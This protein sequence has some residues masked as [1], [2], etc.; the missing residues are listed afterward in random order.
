MIPT[1]EEGYCSIVI[2]NSSVGCTNGIGMY[3]ASR[4]ILDNIRGFESLTILNRIF[5]SY[6]NV[7]PNDIRLEARRVESSYS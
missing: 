3:Q 2:T 6:G 7:V 4:A 1:I 5:D